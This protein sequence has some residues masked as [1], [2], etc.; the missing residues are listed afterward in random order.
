MTKEPKD[1]GRS[2][3]INKKY[4][5]IRHRVEEGHLV[6]KRV[7]SEDNLV[8]PFMRVLSKVKHNQRARSIGLRD[9]VSFNG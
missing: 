8:D 7:S 4:H 9:Y 3:H 2:K 1:H 6:V 5:Y